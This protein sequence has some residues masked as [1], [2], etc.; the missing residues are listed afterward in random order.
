MTPK[1]IGENTRVCSQSSDESLSKSL[2]Q[3][4]GSCISGKGYTS[5]RSSI[6]PFDN[7]AL[8]HIVNLSYRLLNYKNTHHLH[9]K[10]EIPNAT[11][12]NIKGRA[13]TEE[14]LQSKG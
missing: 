5:I 1:R 8:L 14:N 3:I 10:S 6:S 2:I 12:K 4:F 13:S 9:N 11:R 7:Y